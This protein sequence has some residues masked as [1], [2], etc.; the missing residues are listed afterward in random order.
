MESDNVIGAFS[1][2]QASRI[3]GVSLYQLR[4]WDRDGFFEPSFGSAR[5]HTPFGR[6][7]S[8][9]DLVS[10]QVLSDLRNTKRIPLAHLKEVSRKLSHLGDRRW[11]ATTLWVLGKRVVFDDPRSGERRD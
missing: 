11:I 6:I 5:P 8:F 2:E 7:Y 10:L 1:E 9:R 3:S 4:R